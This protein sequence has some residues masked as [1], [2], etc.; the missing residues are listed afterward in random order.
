VSLAGSKISQ[1]K[2]WANDKEERKTNTEL[3]NK[4]GDREKINVEGKNLRE[5]ILRLF[6]FT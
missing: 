1:N 4:K 6:L 2:R 3:K 5:E